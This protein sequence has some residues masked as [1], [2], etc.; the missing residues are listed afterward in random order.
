[1]VVVKAKSR[2]PRARVY[3]K[4]TAVRKAVRKVYKKNFAR[5]VKAVLDR[6]S[7]T[8]VVNFFQQGRSLYNIQSTTWINSVLILT[9]ESAG[10][11]NTCYTIPQGQGQGS[12]I[13]N[14]LRLKRCY[15]TGVVRANSAYDATINNNPCPLRVTMWIVSINKHL[16]DSISNLDIIVDP[17]TGTFFQQGNT[18]SGFQGDTADLTKMINTDVV[19]VHKKRT[20]M[21]GMG[22]YN[23]AVGSN[24]ANNI[25]QQYNNNDASF[26]QMFRVDV[27]KMLPSSYRFNDGSDT[28]TNVRKRYLM[29]TCQRV[30]GTISTTSTGSVTG[31]VPAFVDIGVNFEYKDI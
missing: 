28:P 13:A 23:S 21:L 31:P 20:F 24:V 6:N 16:A 4:R 9:P 17:T 30:D 2:K 12:R 25:Q 26:S 8:K 11:A 29:F 27:T 18:S 19:R 1:M 14:E 10:G 7:E 5:R 22:N 3:R 15:I